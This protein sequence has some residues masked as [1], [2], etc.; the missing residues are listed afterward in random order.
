MNIDFTEFFNL[1]YSERPGDYWT[2]T[3]GC[4]F[5]L[6]GLALSLFYVLDLLKY[7]G[8]AEGKLTK[9]EP[10]FRTRR[11]QENAYENTYSYTVD[12]NRYTKKLKEG[13]EYPKD[14]TVVL[15]YSRKDP[16]LARTG[17]NNRMLMIGLALIVIG[18]LMAYKGMQIAV[19][20]N[21]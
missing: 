15:S 9:S 19:S 10:T 6:A 21:S 16:S 18:I 11:G 3:L 20:L 14:H 5:A 12:G 8:K 13:S 1:A 2:F 7:S 4:L 17:K